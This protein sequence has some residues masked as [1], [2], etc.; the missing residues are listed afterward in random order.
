M[1]EQQMIYTQYPLQFLYLYLDGESQ[2]SACRS[3][4][5]VKYIYIMFLGGFIGAE[6]HCTTGQGI[7]M[8]WRYMHTYFKYIG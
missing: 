7:L 2:G 6:T 8:V 5:H 4:V 3:I 1:G